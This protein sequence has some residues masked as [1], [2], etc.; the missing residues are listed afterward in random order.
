[1]NRRDLVLL[2]ALAALFITTSAAFAQAAEKV[3]RVGVLAPVG[4]R[5]I[6]TFKER[7][8][9]LGW[10]EGQNNLAHP[11]GNVTGSPRRVSSS[12]KNASSCCASWCPV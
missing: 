2:S 5:P 6:E 8:R 12:R 11:G 10:K 4:I 7:L 9:K 3:Y 1:M